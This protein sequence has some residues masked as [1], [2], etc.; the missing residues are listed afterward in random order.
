[1]LRDAATLLGPA[2]AQTIAALDLGEEDTAA[3]QL[4]HQYARC[5]DEHH[6]TA[7]AM[8]WIAPLLHDVLESL[9]ATPAARA[10]LKG[11]KPAPDATPNRLHALRAARRG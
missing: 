7:W 2:V 9:G 11:G 6:D 8:R 10:R 4:A 1:M 5:I 3:V